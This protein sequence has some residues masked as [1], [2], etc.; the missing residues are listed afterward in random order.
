MKARLEKLMAGIIICIAILMMS[1]IKVNAASAS[2]NISSVSGSI[3]DTV[4]VDVVVTSDTL[5]SANLLI[6]YDTNFLELVSV[7]GGDAG[8]TAGVLN[9]VIFRIEAGKSE[10]VTI[11][12]RLKQAGTTGVS[13]LDTT[14]VAEMSATVAP[15]DAAMNIT[16][17]NGTVNIKAATSASS[18]SHLAGFVVQA[19]SQSGD[20]QTVSYSPSFSPEVFEYKADLPANTV[21]LVI[22]TTLSDKNST[23]KVSGTRIDPGDNKTTITVVAEDGSQSKYTLYTTRPNE[24][25]TTTNPESPQ[26]SSSEL[27]TTDFDRSPKLISDINKYIIQDFSLVS[28]PEGFEEGTATYNGE[29][30]AAVKGIAKG[31]TLLCLA[32]DAQGS[33]AAF[34]I[35]NEISGAIDKM[36]NITSS[37]KIYTIIPTGDEYVGPNGYTKTE[38]DING[39][40]VNAWVKTPDSGF[41]VV[42]A[43]NWD[44]E[45]ALYIY[46]S[47]EQTMQRFV[48]G[49][50]SES[51]DDEPGEENKEYLA[52]KRKYDDMYDEYVNDHSKKNKIIIALGIVVICAAIGIVTLIYKLRN[53]KSDYIE[54]N[55]DEDELEE[56]GSEQGQK[57]LK[58][59]MVAQ[60]NEMKAEKLAAQIN[61]MMNE[62]ESEDNDEAVEENTDSKDSKAVNEENADSE[63]DKAAAKESNQ[64]EAE[65][66]DAD[67]DKVNA[68]VSTNIAN[69]AKVNANVSTN[70]A[71]SANKNANTVASANANTSTNAVNSANENT[72][73]NAA[74]VSTNTTNSD[75]LAKSD[76]NANGAKLENSSKKSEENEPYLINMEDDD[77]FEIEFVDLNDDDDD[78]K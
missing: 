69:S 53:K 35:Y 31:L 5:A 42:Y 15:E 75:N 33:N 19:V 58:L 41:Y 55:D 72:N 50:K 26:E 40:K 24:N 59:D 39:E 25:E 74:K 71:N 13:V 73:T 64:N 18:D 45:K 43:M 48:E 36:I 70:A 10:K 47:K 27:Q 2:V 11:N 17:T 52:M 61:E 29:T 34:Y 78:T 30:I 1:K 21:K 4:G 66:N 16:K 20:S 76:S 37:Q 7:E 57:E 28:I 67:S 51:V 8:G 63:D 22:S 62:S 9:T 49:N 60:V 14:S 6:G 23:T 12:F 3:G 65:L 77:P 38:L 46:D 32:D 68:N 56:I 44:G 54:E